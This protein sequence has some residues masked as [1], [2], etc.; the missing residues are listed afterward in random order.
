MMS[1][2]SMMSSSSFSI[3]PVAAVRQEVQKDQTEN[4]QQK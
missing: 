4:V 3:K 2:E 1:K